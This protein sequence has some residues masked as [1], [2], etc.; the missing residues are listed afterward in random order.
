MA[1]LDERRNLTQGIYN[2]PTN[3]DELRRLGF[4]DDSIKALNDAI[5]LIDPEA[6][7]EVQKM[8]DILDYCKELD[9]KKKKIR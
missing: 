4:D 8:Q 1:T 2:L 6:S 9:S 3:D 5:M 7:R